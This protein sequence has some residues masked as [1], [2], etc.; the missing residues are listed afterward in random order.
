M[1]V[2]N[3]ARALGGELQVSLSQ[4]LANLASAYDSE[5]AIHVAH[6][7][8]DGGGGAQSFL[9]PNSFEWGY[10]IF[11][12]K[13]E[14][15]MLKRAL[16]LS[17]V[18]LTF[19][20]LQA[21]NWPGWRGPNSD[22]TASGKGYV[23]SWDNSKNVLWK[24]SLPSGSGSTPAVW[25]DKVFVTSN[26]NGK[27]SILCLNLKGKELWKKTFAKERKGKHRKG[28]G[29]NPS[30]AVDAQ[31]V[32]VYYKSGELVALTHGGDVAWKKNLQ[33]EYGEDTLWWDLGTS[34]VLTKKHVVVAVMH[35]G[36]SFLVA[37]DKKSGK[38][39]WK[40]DRDLGAPSEAAQ[41]YSTP[42]VV[43][44]DGQQTLVVLGAD[45]VTAHQAS[46]GKELWR[47]GDMNPGQNKYFRSIASPVVTKNKVWAP[48]ARGDTLTVIK[49]GGKGD[50]T[51]SH[52]ESIKKVSADVPTP[53]AKDGRV[54][55]LTDKGTIACFNDKTGDQI[56][57]KH[58]AKGRAGF[59]ASPI[60]ADGKIYVVREDGT[61]YVL[62]QGD[63][64]KLLS[65][66]KIPEY[67][68]ASPVL[69]DGKILIKT[70]EH[71]Y[72]IGKK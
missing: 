70:Y 22:G 10:V 6:L 21:D 38:E 33:K 71:L 23:K 47:V 65:T 20:T 52:V 46:D 7:T 61:T 62:A 59:S 1:N 5:N 18:V 30:P 4:I 66:N 14:M 55:V 57:K 44:K 2:A 42:V 40:Q 26:I 54:Y 39:A 45:H 72:C 3:L 43:E 11:Y 34:P 13:L 48:Y 12:E 56:W 53:A 17:A 51:K 41:S 9:P 35:S 29:C 49:M 16:L 63:K 58:I 15:D 64:Y 31:H 36:P 68:L 50:V 60:L 67:T 8:R 19:N 28:S 24:Y 32:Y 69:V 27:N 37:F 25:G